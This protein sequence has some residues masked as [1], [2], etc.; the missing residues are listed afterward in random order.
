MRLGKGNEL[1]KSLAVI[2]LAAGKGTRMKSDLVKILHPI[3]GT[4]M[5]ALTLDLA[6]S[7]RP[8][9][10][11]VV[12]GS[13]RNLVREQFGAEDLLFVDQEEQLGTGHAVLTAGPALKDFQGTVLI[14][15]A[16][17]PL[18]S[19]ETVKKFI[20]AHEEGLNTLSVLTTCLENPSGYGR[21]FRGEKGQLLRIVEEKDLRAGE[22]T[23]REI[24]TGIYCIEAPFLFSALLGLSDQNAQ[25]EYY[26]T[27]IVA[28][29]SSQGKKAAAYLTEDPR[30]VMGINTRLDLAKANQYLRHKIAERHMLEGVTLIDPQ[31]TY[32]DHQVEIG[33]DTVLYPNCY[34]LGKTSLGKNCLIEPGCKIT[35]T[36]VGNFVTIKASSVVSESIIEDRVEVGP[37]AHLRPLTVLRE[38]SRIGNFVEVKKSVIGKG[39]KANHLSYL[40]DATVGEKVN[41]GAGTIFCNYDGRKKHPTLIEDG[42]FVGSNTEL[43]API[44]I[45]RN[46]IIGAGSTITKEVPPDHLAVSRARQVNYKRRSRRKD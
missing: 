16:D 41:I 14:L 22:E 25:K 15:C 30:E 8:D 23:I 7:F 17:V 38:G 27:D 40:G 4:P 44:K 37:F 35:D 10:L 45:G 13:Q 33:R 46:A 11:V 21:V 9:R 12:V 3:A 34:L 19:E 29:A 42:V 43:V 6:R 36:Q 26:L 20:K 32:I 31:T 1:V 5:L 18:L 28:K 24:N 39:T 2:I